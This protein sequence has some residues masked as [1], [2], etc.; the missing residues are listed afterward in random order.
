[1]AKTV[2]NFEHRALDLE[3]NLPLVYP[4]MSKHLFYM[5]EHIS[6]HV[7]EN[8]GVPLNPFMIFNYFLGDTVDRD[9]IR[10]GNNS[11]VATSSELWMYGP[12][13]DGA[14][15]EILQAKKQNKIVRYF[16]IVASKDIV[17]QDVSEADLEQEIAGQRHLLTDK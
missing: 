7:L 16:K 14:L 2:G 13:S 10:R 15:A 12:I 5:R 4:A 9:L 11:L 3:G 6:R 17:E 1:M 8:G